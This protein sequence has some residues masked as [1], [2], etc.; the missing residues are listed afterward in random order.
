MPCEDNLQDGC[1]EK[2]KFCG[3][4]GVICVNSIIANVNGEV[5]CDFVEQYSRSMVEIL[6]ALYFLT[7][8]PSI[9]FPM[10]LV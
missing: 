6:E 9:M 8:H 7:T 2:G 10:Q 3:S 5:F 4:N 1:R